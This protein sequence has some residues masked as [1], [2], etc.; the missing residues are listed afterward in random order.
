MFWYVLITCP[1]LTQN[2]FLSDPV[3]TTT[4]NTPATSATTTAISLTNTTVA[5]IEAKEVTDTA[6]S[7]QPTDVTETSRGEGGGGACN[8]RKWT[9][10]P[11]L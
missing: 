1:T 9:T 5:I 10:P 6:L 4:T 11:Y 3:A 7:P 8:Y 2:R